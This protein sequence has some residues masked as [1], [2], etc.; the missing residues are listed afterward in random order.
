MRIIFIDVFFTICIIFIIVISMSITVVIII[1]I[2]II[3]FKLI[4]NIADWNKILQ[5]SCDKSLRRIWNLELNQ[6]NRYKFL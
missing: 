3:I 4:I 5:K 2:I 6:T 1:I